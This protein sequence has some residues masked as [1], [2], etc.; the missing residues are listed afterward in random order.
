MGICPSEYQTHSRGISEPNRGMRSF[1][2]LLA[3]QER[4][5]QDQSFP[6]D[7][8]RMADLVVSERRLLLR[9]ANYS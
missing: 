6:A 1:D 5:Q 7:V 4:A 3:E 2:C 9:D 8:L